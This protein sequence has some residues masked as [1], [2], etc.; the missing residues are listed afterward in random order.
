M[1]VTSQQRARATILQVTNGQRN[2]AKAASNS[3]SL[4]AEGDVDRDSRLIQGA[5]G[6]QELPAQTSSRFGQPFLCCTMSEISPT[7]CR[8]D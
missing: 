6:F 7:H 5:L 3:L 1:Y 4:L 2:L 8:G